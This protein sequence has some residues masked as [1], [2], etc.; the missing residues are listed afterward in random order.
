MRRTDAPVGD[1]GLAHQDDGNRRGFVWNYCLS[2][3]LAGTWCWRVMV[4]DVRGRGAA[5]HITV[6][7][8]A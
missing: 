4:G 2:V 7:H 3:C 5:R 1:E 6:S 8:V